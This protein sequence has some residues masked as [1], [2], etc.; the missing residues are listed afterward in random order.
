MAEGQI[1]IIKMS[2]SYPGSLIACHQG[3]DDKTVQAVK[4]ALLAFEPTGKHKAMLVDWD[5]TE[6]PLGFTVLNESELQKVK[7]LAK[8]YGLLVNEAAD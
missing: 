4:E 1:K 6:M 5:R 3:L 2:D 8:E 7:D